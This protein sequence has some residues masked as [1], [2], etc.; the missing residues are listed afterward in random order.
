MRPVTPA[1][2]R[3]MDSVRRP[4]V[5]VLETIVGVAA[6]IK[7]LELASATPPWLWLPLVAVALATIVLRSRVAF[8][9][10]AVAVLAVQLTPAYSNHAVVL[11]WL[12]VAL[13]VTE[14]GERRLW[15]LRWQLSLM[16]GF[17][18]VSKLWPDWLSG[19]ALRMWT[20]VGPLLPDWSLVAVAC[21]TVL[22]EVTLA[23]HAWRP[24]RWTLALAVALHAPSVVFIESSPREVVHL[25]LFAVLSLGAWWSVV[26]GG[27]G[28][29]TMVRT[30]PLSHL[31]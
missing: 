19:D 8:G 20:W 30:R 21:A 7:G 25:G 2:P 3:S 27:E 24:R 6:V 16:Y 23:A 31:E 12:A 18:A 5:P 14:P 26:M 10:L 15:L 17:A 1:R 28:L 11:F 29:L 9:A 22:V 13:A 4:P